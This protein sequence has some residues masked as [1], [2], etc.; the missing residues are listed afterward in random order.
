MLHTPKCS[1]R[2]SPGSRRSDASSRECELGPREPREHD[3]LRL[4]RSR[5]ARPRRIKA[6]A[7]VNGPAAG[8]AKNRGCIPIQATENASQRANVS[9]V[10]PRAC[11]SSS[12]ITLHDEQRERDQ[13]DHAKARRLS[14]AQ[15]LD[16]RCSDDEDRPGD[17]TRQA[18]TSRDAAARNRRRSR[19]TRIV[20]QRQNDPGLVGTYAAASVFTRPPRN[21]RRRSGRRRG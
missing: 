18:R 4:R 9:G 7:P 5:A 15:P 20:R 12:T 2:L 3:Q 1:I 10:R 14:G 6:T 21:R 16:S 19:A 17:D 11:S 8:E 13:G